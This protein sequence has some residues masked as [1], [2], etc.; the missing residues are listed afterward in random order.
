MKTIAVITGDIVG[1]AS[2]K[3]ANR[4]FLITSLKKT[5][6]E[7][8]KVLLNTSKSPFEIY[9]GDS[10]QAEIEKPELSLLIS[11][12]IRAKIRSL[13][14]ANEP[15]KR[16][17]KRNWDARIAI[18]IGSLAFNSGKTIESDGQAFQFSG[19][20]ID[21]MKKTDSRLKILTPWEDVNS[22]LEVSFSFADDVISQ[23]SYFQAE[24]FYHYLLNEETQN[25][26]AKIIHRSQPSA[27]KRLVTGKVESIDKF[28]HRFTTLISSKL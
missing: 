24:A 12:L 21:G 25:S 18:G 15:K 13:M 1:S 6:K 27:R 28:L 4:E 3:E 8:S 10:F 5:F 22:E 17:A 26:L 2:I 7:I 20:L 23:W 16:S 11:L 9:R 14:D 19:M